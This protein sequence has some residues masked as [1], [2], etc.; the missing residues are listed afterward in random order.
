MNST[1]NKILTDR[2]KSLGNIRHY[3]FRRAITVEADLDDAVIDPGDGGEYAVD[4]DPAD[5]SS[6]VDHL[7]DMLNTRV[8]E[9][10]TV[11]DYGLVDFDRIR[12]CRIPLHPQG[13]A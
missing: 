5:F 11:P 7:A 9:S 1:F 12:R 13:R 2:Q 10:V 6:V 8:G 4:I 3:N